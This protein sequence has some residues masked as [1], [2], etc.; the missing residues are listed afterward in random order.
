MEATSGCPYIRISVSEPRVKL[1][2]YVQKVGSKRM[3]LRTNP[4][5]KSSLRSSSS[6]ST[7][8]E[9]AVKR[10]RNHSMTHTYTYTHRHYGVSVCV[11]V[12]LWLNWNEIR[13]V[14]RR[15]LNLKSRFI[16]IVN[17]YAD[18]TVSWTKAWQ[19]WFTFPWRL[20][21]RSSKNGSRTRDGS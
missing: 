13:R 10:D 8:W 2:H 14:S 5:G 18:E 1:L 21:L 19:S 12:C 15:I 11:C 7:V 4:Q 16:W 9:T 6:S 3:K 17:M 20:D